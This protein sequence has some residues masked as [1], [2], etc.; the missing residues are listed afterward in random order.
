M[1]LSTKQQAFVEH[2]LS[3]F[4]ATKAAEA[5]GYAYPRQ[6]GSRLLTYVDIQAAIKARLDELKMSADEVLTRLADQARFNPLRFTVIHDAGDD[7]APR[8]IVGINLAAIE[9]AGLGSCV[10]KI[11]YDRNGLMVVEFYDGQAALRL[12]GQHHKLFTQ[13]QELRTPDLRPLPEALR[14]LANKVYG[15]MAPQDTPED[16][17]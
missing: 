7:H 15:A 2:Y 17:D 8:E 11:S 3:C 1:A 6:A 12:I 4:N 10:K 5:A 13:V 16:G 14:E 9:A